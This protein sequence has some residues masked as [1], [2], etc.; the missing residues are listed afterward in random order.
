MGKEKHSLQGAS[1]LAVHKGERDFLKSQPVNC[2]IVQSA[3]F[4]YEDV[5]QLEK[6][7]AGDKE[8]YLYGRYDNPTLRTAEEKMAALEGAEAALVLSSGLAAIAVII[9]SLAQHG[10]EILT[11]PNIYGGTHTLFSKI[12]PRWDIRVTFCN[13]REIDNIEALI[14]KKTKLIH[15]ETPTNPLLEIVDIAYIAEI[16]RKHKVKLVV[17]NTFATPINQQPLKL[18][19]DV[20][21]H[22]ATK[23]LGGHDDLMGGFICS[24]SD[25][26]EQFWEHR[27]LLGCCMN[28]LSGY[29][30]LRGMKTIELRV[31]RQ[32]SNALRIADF[33]SQHPRV[34]RVYYPGLLSNTYYH[35]ARKQMSGFGGIV[36][37]QLAGGL[38]EVRK[39]AD[40]LKLCLNSSSLGG[41][42][43]MFLLPVLTSHRD[44]SPE[45]REK[46]GISEGMIR[47][48]L[49]I[50]NP[51][52]IIADLS[53]ALE[54]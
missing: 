41:V 16:A 24:S 5:N 52:D 43:T 29:L 50:E 22:S 46:V 13:L 4:F 27:R 20:I 14:N 11:L 18:G 34:E 35:L 2:P 15:I 8:L 48:S 51:E 49:G 28:P 23:Y 9:S 1:T 7:I 37:F 54:G 39:V 3:T 36:S 17:D 12:L 42:N 47:L 6:Y 25:L 10:D 45:E 44:L 21:I 38:K 32:N 40:R 19:A 53:Q 26:I 31:Q 33:L 30:L